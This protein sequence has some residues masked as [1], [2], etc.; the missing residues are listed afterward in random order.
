MEPC[1]RLSVCSNREPA[2]NLPDVVRDN[3]LSPPDFVVHLLGSDWLAKFAR[4]SLVGCQGAGDYSS[5]LRSLINST[6]RVDTVQVCSLAGSWWNRCNVA[7]SP[8][9]GWQQG[10]AWQIVEMEEYC[11]RLKDICKKKCFW[12][13]RSIQGKLLLR[14][15]LI[16]SCARAEDPVSKV[17]NWYYLPINHSSFLGSGFH[18]NSC[19]DRLTELLLR[20]KSNLQWKDFHNMHLLDRSLKISSSDV[21][22]QA[23]ET[24]RP[25]GSP[26]TSQILTETVRW[27]RGRRPPCWW[28]FVSLSPYIWGAYKT[29]SLWRMF[30]IGKSSWW[31]VGC[32]RQGFWQGGLDLGWRTG[33]SFPTLIFD[34]L[35]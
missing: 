23:A 30:L 35:W 10:D 1:L 3:G 20:K 8:T 7:T 5:V 27:A 33:K 32:H 28:G 15:L 18:S 24:K 29:S 25:T 14:L 9:T 34:R 6:P 13:M 4:L 17:S 2:V 16:C 26:K 11:K 31:L 19:V 22:N 12:A 21:S